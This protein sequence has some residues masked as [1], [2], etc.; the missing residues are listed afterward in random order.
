MTGKVMEPFCI[1]NCDGLSAIIK[2]GKD[3]NV[4]MC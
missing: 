1:T 4:A 2:L 3:E